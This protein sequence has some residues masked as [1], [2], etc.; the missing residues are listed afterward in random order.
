MD[1]PEV[2]CLFYS[3]LRQ[4]VDPDYAAW[5]ERTE[6]LVRHS[7]GYLRHQSYRDPRTGEGLTISYFADDGA[8]RAWRQHV[9]HIEAQQLG[10]D[11][12]YS[13]FRIEVLRLSRRR[14]W[15]DE[16]TPAS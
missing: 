11:R 10:R 12:F 15:H 8:M 14:E 3:T 1:S 5:S 16:T 4:P 13:S 7:P 2:A 9:E 6:E